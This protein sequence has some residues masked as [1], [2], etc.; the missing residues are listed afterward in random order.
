M[1]LFIPGQ[2]VPFR[3]P[4]NNVQGGR[5]NP[6]KMAA[7]ERFCTDLLRL[8]W[9]GPQVEYAHLQVVLL[10]DRPKHMLKP[11]SDPN[12]CWCNVL[13]DID[14][15]LKVLMDAIKKAGIVYDDG[16]VVRVDIVKLYRAVN[17][18]PGVYLAI[19]EAGAPPAWAMEVGR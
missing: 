2:P 6:A 10:M 16:R 8:H 9:R 3:R 13:P 12:R 5:R 1:M 15:L 17:E 7:Y 14:N 19:T 18:G 11:S 4:A